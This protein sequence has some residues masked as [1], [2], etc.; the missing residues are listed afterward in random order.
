M[1]FANVYVND[2]DQDVCLSIWLLRNAHLVSGINLDMDIARLIIGEDLLDASAGVYPIDPNRPLARKMAWVFDL[3][4]EARVGGDLYSMNTVQMQDVI[5]ATCERLT[6]LSEGNAQEK[7]LLGEYDIVGGSGEWKIVRENGTHARTKLFADGIRAFVA[8]RER[9]D[10][11]Y[12]YSVGRM[13]PF[14]QFP[15]CKIF[16]ALNEAED[17]NN[18]H[19]CWGGSDTIGG[20]PRKTGSRLAPSE[21][22]RIINGILQSEKEAQ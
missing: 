20:S 22:E 2:C 21:I 7:E 8:V 4:D 11:T 14:I 1:P 12:N 18:S 6:L 13:S 19:D 16:H 17:C 3:Y 15:L 10:S 9:S 5:E